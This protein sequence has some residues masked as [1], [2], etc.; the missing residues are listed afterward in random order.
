MNP[1]T[2]VPILGQARQEEMLRAA[3]TL[4]FKETGSGDLHCHFFIPPDFNPEEPGSL[5]LFFHGGY[6]DTSTPTQ[7]VPHARHFAARGALTATV[8]TRVRAEHGTGPMEAL[9]D[10]RD[11][12][13]WLGKHA[14]GFGI[15]P[16][17]VVLGG[18]SGGAFLA[19]SQVLPRPDRS[20]PAA[21]QPA[22]LVL[23]SALLDTTAA[24]VSERFPDARSARAWSPLNRCKARKLPPMILFHGKNDRVNPFP[25][26]QKFTKALRWRRNRVELVDYER[27]EHSF[28]NFNL[29]EFH[30]DLT[31][32]AADRFLCDHGLLEPC[33]DLV[34]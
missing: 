3:V 32:K 7:F 24:S 26:A 11:L 4:P 8:E 34:V 19:L 28:F 13:N 31:L 21:L 10:V 29:S 15:D 30:Y 2:K 5:V 20:D 14:D 22:A 17:R 33:E 12:L 16:S 27:A 25:T 1:F 23:F 9:E 18:A 6:W